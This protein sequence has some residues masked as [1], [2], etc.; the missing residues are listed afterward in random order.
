MAGKAPRSTHATRS[1][2][3]PLFDWLDNLG[4]NFYSESDPYDGEGSKQAVGPDMYLDADAGRD[5]PD[6]SFLGAI[7]GNL[8]GD[9]LT[10]TGNYLAGLIGMYSVTGA[11]STTYP[12]GA[13]IGGI[14]DGVTEA[15]GAFVAFIDGDS[16][17]TTAGAAFK[18]MN[19]NSTAASGFD[20]GVDLQDSAHDGYQAVDRDFYLKAPMRLV[21]D[22]VFLTGDG[23]PTSGASGTGDNVAGKGSV[24]IDITNGKLY[25]QGGAIT[26][27]DWK[28]VTSA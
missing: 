15:N 5:A 23:A 17:T 28:L 22:V 25:V 21:D 20:F 3:S 12:A 8:I 11:K 19:N 4:L 7:M 10:K 14:A 9:A 1:W 27:P 2:L 24:Y 16:E 13:V 26:A 18:V 6:T